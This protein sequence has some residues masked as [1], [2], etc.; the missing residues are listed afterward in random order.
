M[1]EEIEVRFAKRVGKQFY[2]DM[3]IGQG[4]CFGKFEAEEED[5]PINGH[6]MVMTSFDESEEVQKFVKKN[7]LKHL[8][9]IPPEKFQEGIEN[10]NRI[11]TL[12]KR[13]KAK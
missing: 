4:Y 8:L 12:P 1:I 10:A 5:D 11:G 13:K 9:F 7:D 2:V 3:N 6:M